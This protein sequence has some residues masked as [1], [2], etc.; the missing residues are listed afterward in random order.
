MPAS[1]IS[2]SKYRISC[3]DMNTCFLCMYNHCECNPSPPQQSTQ[4]YQ[5][6]LEE[7]TCTGILSI[8]DSTSQF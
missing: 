8:D 3:F 5:N 4:K 2:M 1:S 6:A 7:P